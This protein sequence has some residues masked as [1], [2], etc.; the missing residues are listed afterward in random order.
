MFVFLAKQNLGEYDSAYG[1]MY[2]T[3]VDSW[4]SNMPDL[5]VTVSWFVMMLTNIEL[6][7]NK[8]RSGLENQICL[9]M[10]T[11]HLIFLVWV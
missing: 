3:S 9:T 2:F 8:K 6:P 4:L 5:P 11:E 10:K 1:A 7:F